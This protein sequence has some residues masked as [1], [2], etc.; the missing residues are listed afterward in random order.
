MT[1]THNAD[2]L[3]HQARLIFLESVSSCLTWTLKAMAEPHSATLCRSEGSNAFVIL[4]D[5][6]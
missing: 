5:V 4:Y 6:T 2:K 3:E 1:L